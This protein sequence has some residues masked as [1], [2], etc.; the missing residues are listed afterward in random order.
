M[1]N[2][3]RNFLLTDLKV[4][5]GLSSYTI[6]EKFEIAKVVQRCK[7]EYDS[8]CSKMK[9]KWDSKKKRWVESKPR[10]GFYSKAV[11]SHFKNLK[12]VASSDPKL[13]KA[14]H[15]ARRAYEKYG[16]CKS[17]DDLEEGPSKKRF[18]SE[19]AGRKT[20]A[21][22]FRDELYQWFIDV[23]GVLKG[24]FLPYSSV[25][26]EYGHNYHYFVGTS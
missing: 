3:S 13:I 10:E 4:F 22:E 24:T 1:P 17:I 18:R 19:G 12:N 14:I 9:K 23:R 21:L 16:E 2:V 15:V 7:E 8:E 26:D 25:S 6:I 11:R 5:N 20:Q